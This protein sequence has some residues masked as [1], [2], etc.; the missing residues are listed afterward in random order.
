MPA[1]VHV[2]HHQRSDRAW[3]KTQ[4]GRPLEGMLT[5]LQLTSFLRHSR[6]PFVRSL[7]R[8]IV[9]SILSLCLCLS[10]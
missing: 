1:Q 10:L 6:L 7:G 3:P 4:R 2:A 5:G 9:Q 8:Y